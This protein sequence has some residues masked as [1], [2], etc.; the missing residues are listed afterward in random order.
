MDF[1]KSKK[2]KLVIP[3]VFT[4]INTY[5]RLHDYYNDVYILKDINDTTANTSSNNYKVSTDTRNKSKKK[6]KL[7]KSYKH[8][9]ML[10]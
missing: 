2:L 1:S 8:I 10:K 9:R 3:E 4:T 5:Q 7:K 6:Y